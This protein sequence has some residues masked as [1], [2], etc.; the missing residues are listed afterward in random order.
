MD[1]YKYAFWF[2]PFVGSD[3]IMD[4]FENSVMIRE[5]DMRASP[6]DMAPFGLTPVRVETAEGRREY[7]DA[8]HELMVRSDPLR[9]R[10]AKTLQLLANCD[11][12]AARLEDH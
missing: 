2:S 4:C 8:Q 9:E 1:L 6:Y 3:L 11:E 12:D 7:A 10:L 5:L